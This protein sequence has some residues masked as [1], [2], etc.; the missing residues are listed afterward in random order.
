MMPSQDYE[1]FVQSFFSHAPGPPA[2]PN[3]AALARLTGAERVE[4][5]RLLLERLGPDDSRP[6]IGLGVLRSKAAVA[7]LRA[8]RATLLPRIG[9]VGATAIVDV[10]VALYRI[11]GDAQE[12][13]EI[14][15]VLGHAPRPATRKYAAAALRQVRT[16]QASR[17]LEQAV[18]HDTDKLVRFTAAE[19]LLGMH[20]ILKGPLDQHPLPAR[21]MFEVPAVRQKALEDLCA[22]LAAHPLPAP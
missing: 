15:R 3:E 2:P 9:E 8:L 10:C 13:D 5:E 6:A 21:F 17:R 1:K 14:G 7:P 4:A 18:E 11:E 19:S 16:P 12:A 20:G 22:L